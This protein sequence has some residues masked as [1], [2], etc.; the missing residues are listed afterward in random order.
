MDGEYT[1]AGWDFRF[2]TDG[3]LRKLERNGKAYADDSHRWGEVFYENYSPE[4]YRNFY[5]SYATWDVDWAREDFG[6]IGMEKAIAVGLKTTPVLKELLRRGNELLA[7]LGMKGTA[8]DSHG[9]P[10]K[11]GMRSKF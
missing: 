4:D 8:H 1:A 11:W 2:G 5:Q 6:K 9:A 3:S 10:A 7:R